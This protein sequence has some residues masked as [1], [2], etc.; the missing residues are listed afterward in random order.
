MF[1]IDNAELLQ[2][3][4]VK[5]PGSDPGPLLWILFVRVILLPVPFQY[6]FRVQW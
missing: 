4:K 5:G 2:G 3:I 1:L 6:S